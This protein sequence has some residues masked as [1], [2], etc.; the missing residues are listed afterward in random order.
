M[1]RALS[2]EQP[3]E[4]A[5]L[6]K[7]STHAQLARFRVVQWLTPGATPWRQASRVSGLVLT[8]WLFRATAVFLLLTAFVWRAGVRGSRL[9]WRSAD[10]RK[11][12][13][14]GLL[15]AP[16]GFRADTAVLVVFGV[17]LALIAAQPAGSRA[18][19]D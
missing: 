1:Y 17:S 5:V 7:T 9:S 10:C 12:V 11:Q 13:V 2:P 8:S 16:A 14:A 18:C 19:L 6:Q 3:R 15:A 4:P